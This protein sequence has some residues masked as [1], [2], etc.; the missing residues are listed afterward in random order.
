MA[1]AKALG[2][3]RILAVDVQDNRLE[4]AKNYAATDVHRPIPKLPEETSMTYAKR[5]VRPPQ[6]HRRHTDRIYREKPSWKSLV[7][8]S[9]EKE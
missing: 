4:F 2:A 9:G 3:R 5:Q 1:V 7:S 8:E 6:V